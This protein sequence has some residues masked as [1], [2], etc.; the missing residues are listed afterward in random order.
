MLE[1][2]QNGVVWLCNLLISLVGGA[3]DLL[4][5]FLPDSPFSDVVLFYERSGINEFFGYLAWLLPI[6]QIMN[7]LGLWVVCIGIYFIYSI[8]L[9]WIKVVE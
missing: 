1:N 3:L 9:R 2:L 4:L 5:S 6:K 8:A 7:I